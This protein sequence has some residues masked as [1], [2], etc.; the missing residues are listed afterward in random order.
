MASRTIIIANTSQKS[1]Q[2][3]DAALST[4]SKTCKRVHSQES[5]AIAG[6]VTTRM[7]LSALPEMILVVV[8]LNLITVGG[9]SCAFNMV[10]TG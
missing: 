5:L 1:V 7:E 8:G 6:T 2:A 3:R 4:K 10:N 9:N